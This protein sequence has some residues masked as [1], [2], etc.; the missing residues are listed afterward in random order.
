[1]SSKYQ[2]RLLSARGYVT[3]GAVAVALLLY[4]WRHF[5]GG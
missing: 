2:G 3:R 1:M 5:L 4:G